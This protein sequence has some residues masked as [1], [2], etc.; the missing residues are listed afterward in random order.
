MLAFQKHLKSAPFSNHARGLCGS[1]AR[2]SRRP[3]RHRCLLLL[4][5]LRLQTARP[6]SEQ[7]R[8]GGRQL[9]LPAAFPNGAV[10]SSDCCPKNYCS[11]T[12]VAT[13]HQASRRQW[14]TS[15]SSYVYVKK[16]LLSSERCSLLLW[17]T[18]VVLS[19]KQM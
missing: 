17:C 4:V 15:L 6:R 19:C 18:F 8:S 14:T 2:D 3:G 5:V 9:L 7:I 13:R 1:I 11:C 16:Y 10:I 12:D